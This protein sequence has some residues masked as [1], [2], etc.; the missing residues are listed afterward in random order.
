[1]VLNE[2]LE[3]WLCHG[4]LPLVCFPQ[5][6]GQVIQ[7]MAERRKRGVHLPQETMRCELLITGR[8]PLPCVPSRSQP[9]LPG[10]CKQPLWTQSPSCVSKPIKQ[11]GR[12][13]DRLP[14]ETT[15]DTLVFPGIHR[16]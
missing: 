7:S 1:M 2:S 11:Q 9:P 5:R 15:E 14:L 4:P 8:A 16:E 13:P 10:A 3:Q 12:L 6:A